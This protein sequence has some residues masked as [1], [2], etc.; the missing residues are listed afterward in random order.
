MPVP[1]V[2]AYFGEHGVSLPT[3][4]E[5]ADP[6]TIPAEIRTALESID[7]D[8]AHPLNLYRVHWY[9]SADRRSVADAPYSIELPSSLTG[10]S[11]RIVVMVGAFF[12]LI[13][14][15]KVLPAYACLVPRLL[16]GDFDP[17]HHRA[18]W[19]ST[20]NYCR[21]G[22][23]ISKILGC[24]GVAVLPE[25]MSQERFD[26]LDQWVGNSSDIIRTAGTESNVK[27]IYDACHE[28]ARHP[29]NRILNQFSEFPNYVVH[30]LCTGSAL[31]HVFR[32]LQAVSPGAQLKAFVSATGSA[33]TIAAGDHL[34][35]EFGTRIAVVEP[36]ECP[37]LLYNGFGAH[38][39][40]G[41]G[42]KHL[43][44]IH[45]IINN[46]FVVGVSDKASD[47]LD[48]LFNTPVGRDF[49]ASRKGVDQAI[50]DQLGLLGLSSIANI[51]GAVKL[52]KAMNYGPD[53]VI[54]TI[55]TDSAA[56][57][58]SER[59]MAT[60]REF[61][62]G[63]DTIEAAETFGRYLAGAASDHVLEFTENDRNRVFNLGYFT[64]VEQQGVSLQ[65]FEQ[66][67][68]QS[69][70]DDLVAQA[71]VWDDQIRALN[72]RSKAAA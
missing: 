16:S 44:L 43:P 56:M 4:S 28:L 49:L 31:A 27:E 48:V 45:N 10:V 32:D 63:F 66:R 19:P 29:E 36:T 58:G 41:I 13:A 53:D 71:D 47:G 67:R 25:G 55:A 72:A 1:N 35:A 39:I 59:E 12:P 33:G 7:P 30:R 69:F 8:A 24:R 26:W 70:W 37:T 22:V 60:A 68:R 64:W 5:L 40:Q 9:N 11:A 2:S 46:D 52:A 15:H 65:D 17:E 18:V 51:V 61:P 50:I 54:L 34:K 42:D 14:A 62:D 21:G 57:Y 3:F 23:A 38:N 20:G 6:R